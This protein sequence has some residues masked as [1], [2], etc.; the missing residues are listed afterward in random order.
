MRHDR[1]WSVSLCVLSV[2]ALSFL[3]GCASDDEP[4]QTAGEQR[5]NAAVSGLK[6]TRGELASAKGQIEK[7]T[8]TMNAVRDGQGSLQADFAA[9][10]SEVAKTEARANQARERAQDMRARS[11]QYQSK[12]RAE[13][14]K[15]D[16]PALRAAATERANKVRERFEAITTKSNEVRDAYQPYMKQLKSLQTY[17]SNDLTAAGV[18]GATPVFD[19]AAADSKVVTAKIDALIAELDSVA[20]T[21]GPAPGAPAAGATK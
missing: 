9:F 8:T 12:W 1:L 19:K 18:Q 14:A 5:A 15:V 4:K 7:T 10:N 20:S 16:D 21:M 11:G 13:M 17:L 2:A 6:E 3:P